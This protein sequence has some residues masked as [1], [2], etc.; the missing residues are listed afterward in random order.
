MTTLVKV[1]GLAGIVASVLATAVPARRAAPLDGEVREG[2]AVFTD[3]GANVSGITYWVRQPGGWCVV[4]TLQTA[5]GPDSDAAHHAV[6]RFSS[7]LLSGQS[8]WILVP[9]AVGEPQRALRIHRRG[10]RV[11]VVVQPAPDARSPLAF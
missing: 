11:E 5:G 4:T 1:A 6:V 8:Q 9:V 2:Q 10:D 3:L 7:R